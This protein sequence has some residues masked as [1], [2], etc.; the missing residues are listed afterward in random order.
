MPDL[1][2]LFEL[3]NMARS[4]SSITDLAIYYDDETGDWSYQ[5]DDNSVPYPYYR[6]KCCRVEV[7]LARGNR[8]IVH[9]LIDQITGALV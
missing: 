7:H 6:Y 3:V 1:E 8:E 9:D 2:D 5:M 4:I